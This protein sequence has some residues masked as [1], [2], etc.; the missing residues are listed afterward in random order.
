[1]YKYIFVNHFGVMCDTILGLCR[2]TFKVYD[3][4]PAR[5]RACEARPGLAKCGWMEAGEWSVAKWPSRPE[6]R[7]RRIAAERIPFVMCRFCFFQ[8][9]RN[10][11]QIFFWQF[12]KPFLSFCI[13]FFFFYKSFFKYFQFS[14][15][16]FILFPFVKFAVYSI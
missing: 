9:F 5:I 11:L 7:S 8:L 15:I 13:L 10:Y 14:S 2:I 16:N 3:V 6:P 4:L 12:V 1:M